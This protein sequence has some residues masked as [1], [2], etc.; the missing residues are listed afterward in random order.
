MP[1]THFENEV[2]PGF[3]Q[4]RTNHAAVRARCKRFNCVSVNQQH[5]FAGHTT[6]IAGI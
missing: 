5:Y 6:P 1:L 2:P 3:D 4:M